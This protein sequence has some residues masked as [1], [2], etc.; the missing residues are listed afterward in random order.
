MTP[1]SA[2]TL[3][4]WALELDTDDPPDSVIANAASAS[5]YDIDDGQPMR[6]WCDQRRDRPLTHGPDEFGR[7]R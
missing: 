4:E 1:L 7:A 3:V 5:T 6:S 2:A